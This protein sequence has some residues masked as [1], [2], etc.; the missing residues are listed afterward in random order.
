MAITTAGITGAAGTAFLL[1]SDEG[2]SRQAY[3]WSRIF[4][5]ITD[6]WVHTSSSSPWVRFHNYKIHHFEKHLTAL[7]IQKEEIRQKDERISALHEKNAPKILQVML[8]L[9]GLYVKLGQVLSV[10]ALPV[11][12]PYRVRFRTLQSDVPGH[13]EFESIVKPTLEKELLT[14]SSNYK[15]LNDIFEYID[16][17]PCGAASIGQA[18]K[19]SLKMKSATG[20]AP[21]KLAKDVV[22]KI[23]YPNA[24]W[25]VPAD[26]MCVAHFLKICI[27]AGVVDPDSSKMSFEEFSRQFLSELDYERETNN[28]KTVYE[29]SLD[30][31]APYIKHNVVIPQVY[32]DL[33]TKKIITM[34]YIP[35]VTMESEAK[36]QL[37][38]LGIDTSG[39]LSKIIKEAAT[40]A[41]EHPDDVSS[42]DL[43]RRVTKMRRMED[44]VDNDRNNKRKMQLK[45]GSAISNVATR[46]IGVDSILWALRA[47]K[48]VTL[49][50]RAAF[51][52]TIQS[53]PSFL[54]SSEWKEWMEKHRSAAEQAKTLGEIDEWCRALFDVHG[55]QIFNLGLFNADPHPGNILVNVG[56][57]SEGN[58]RSRSSKNRKSQIG[59]IDYGQV[60]SLTEEEKVKVARLILSVA[61]NE[62]DEVIA[63]TLRDMNIV[64]KNDSTEFLAT[65]AKLMFGKFK[66]EYLQRS[67]H[68]KLHESDRI[69]YFPKE[70]SMVY[71]TSLLLRGLGV[72]L[73]LNYSVG[74]EW[75]IHAQHCVDRYEE[76]KNI[77]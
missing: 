32:Q 45:I 13:E 25:Q 35:G 29:S 53:L 59:L 10:T 55:H 36:R 39:G 34:S 33:C 14:K 64:T 48:K 17:I 52:S 44:D 71:R 77:S 38:M 56:G 60:K 27:W 28:L 58:Q 9:K 42:G 63:K 16:P 57:G 12:E 7:E 70:L 30:S 5:I 8:D 75:K 51:V 24:A 47:G 23:Q 74:E 40:E 76:K 2:L 65:F 54:V 41:T 73:Q 43:V 1:H 20:N 67:F 3:F 15:T 31:S 4:P 26:I 62:K 19:A 68:K 61:N 22:I 46:L 21:T 37:E 72:S 18:H 11:P 50:Y 49:W 6:Y 69:L 66:P